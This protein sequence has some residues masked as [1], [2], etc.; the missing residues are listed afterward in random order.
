M[1]IATGQRLRKRHFCDVRTG[2]A[3][4]FYWLKEH[5]TGFAQYMRGKGWTVIEAET[6]ADV[7]IAVEAQADDIVISADSDMLAYETIK[8]LWR[9]VSGGQALVY[10]IP[11]LL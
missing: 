1:R 7:A 10:S 11:A 4:S 9:P 8:T 5:R 3:S 6:E 2:L